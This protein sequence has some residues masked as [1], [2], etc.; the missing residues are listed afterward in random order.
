M[1]IAYVITEAV[2]FDPADWLRSGET[3]CARTARSV[4]SALFIAEHQ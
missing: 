4:K 2:G 3:H 1:P